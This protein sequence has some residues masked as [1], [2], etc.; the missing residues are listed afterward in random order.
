[1]TCERVKEIPFKT[2][3]AILLCLNILKL[4]LRKLLFIGLWADFHL[5]LE[6]YFSV[7]IKIHF[8]LKM[9]SEKPF[10]I[11]AFIN[12]NVKWH[13][14]W[15]NLYDRFVNSIT[16]SKHN[17]SHRKI[18]FY[19][20]FI[21]KKNL[22]NIFFLFLFLNLSSQYFHFILYSYD[23]SHERS[24]EIS[25]LDEIRWCKLVKSKAEDLYWNFIFLSRK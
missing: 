9:Y 21:L 12:L 8:M 2:Y 5:H 14:F 16:I 23:V 10:N 7:T 24:Y 19:E 11:N 25:S 17:F 6:L 4:S 20:K 18:T 22:C 15:V 13:W 3:F 1:M